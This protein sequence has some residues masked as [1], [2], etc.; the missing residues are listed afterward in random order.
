MLKLYNF[1]EIFGHLSESEDNFIRA[2]S[3]LDLLLYEE[4]RI[5]PNETYNGKI[6]WKKI[7]EM[8][9]TLRIKA[10]GFSPYVGDK[11]KKN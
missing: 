7:H 10:T 11:N 6:E 9:Q 2:N 4:V 8:L 1:K 5:Y 3:N